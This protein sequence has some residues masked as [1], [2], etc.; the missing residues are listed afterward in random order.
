MW[1][2]MSRLFTNSTTVKTV[3]TAVTTAGAKIARNPGRAAAALGTTALGVSFYDDIF[4]ALVGQGISPSDIQ[5]LEGSV[6]D[7]REVLCV[8]DTPCDPA[9]MRDTRMMQKEYIAWVMT[10]TCERSFLDF[11][12]AIA[13]MC[14]KD[15]PAYRKRSSAPTLAAVA[16]NQALVKAALGL[17]E[18]STPTTASA[19]VVV[20]PP[21]D[22]GP[23]APATSGVPAPPE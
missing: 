3:R 6:S 23:A 13:S 11:K 21:V 1:N 2:A 12:N 5:A 10:G 18:S 14:Y 20:T 19:P 17:I 15:L 9:L 4:A 8:E 7:A 22:G 16:L